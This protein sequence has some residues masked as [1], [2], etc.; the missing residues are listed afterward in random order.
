MKVRLKN[1]VCERCKTV[2]G[3]ELK[4]AGINILS[5][6][7]GELII[8]DEASVSRSIL[9]EIAERNGFEI[10]D[11]KDTVLVENVKS[12]L[13]RKIEAL[14]EFQENISVFL[15][16][17]LNTDYSIISKCFKASTGITIEKYLIRLKVEKAKELLQMHSMTFSE[18]AYSLDYSGGSHLAKQ[19]KNSTGMSMTEYK[20]L[21]KWKIMK[22]TFSGNH[23][24]TE[25]FLSGI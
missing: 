10:I 1:M 12:I 2:L 22:I 19:F 25:E 16:K 24:F 5:I 6:E 15:S 3:Q 20:R 9:K 11:S 4:K 21:Q 8:M 18:I 13:I 23:V 14:H 17:E 7:L